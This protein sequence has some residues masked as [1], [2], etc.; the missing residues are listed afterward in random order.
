MDEQVGEASAVKYGD[1]VRSLVDTL[2]AYDDSLD[3]VVNEPVQSIVENSEVGEAASKTM[4]I[5]LFRC[6]NYFASESQ[7]VDFLLAR[8][9]ASQREA[10]ELKI[11]IAE[12]EGLGMVTTIAQME[13][14]RRSKEELVV[15]DTNLVERLMEE[16][17]LMFDILIARLEQYNAARDCGNHTLTPIYS[18][19]LHDIPS[20][21]SNLGLKNGGRL[22][23]FLATNGI[24]QSDPRAT[25]AFKV[26]NT[27]ETTFVSQPTTVPKLTWA[28]GSKS[29]G[30]VRK[31]SL[32]DI[33]K[34]ELESKAD[35]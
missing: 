15:K 31:V 22:D 18:N 25:G 7:C 24:D 8:I 10:A 33:Q 26:P 13:E 12:C 16:A 14:T 35:T 20:L 29:A 1:L 30:L 3:R 27:I 17:S 21:I 9:H 2:K 5:F 34:E 6:R 32:L 23:P 4:D 19:T 11:E 28:N